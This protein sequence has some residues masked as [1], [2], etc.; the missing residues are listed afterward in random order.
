M[1]A[2]VFSLHQ[3]NALVGS[4][5]AAELPREVLLTA[6]LSE[7]RPSPRGYCFV[8]FV[9]RSE[10]SGQLV[11]KARGTIWA[12]V[13]TTLAPL[14]AQITGA[15]LTAG[16]QVLVR[17]SADFHPLYGYALTVHDIDPAYTVGDMARRR[18]EIL[19]R[20]QDDGVIAL[21][22]E[23][24]EPR[25]LRRIALISSGA[26]AGYG[27]FVA[28][29]RAS[30]HPFHVELFQATMQGR[31]VEGSIIAALER[32][33][34]RAAD[35]DAV[36]IVRGGGAVS[37]LSGFDAYLLAA[38]VAQF[39]LPVFTGIGHERD[40]TVIDHVAHLRL[41]TPTAVA[42]YFID[43]YRAEVELVDSLSQRLQRALVLSLQREQGR[44]AERAQRI[45]RAA[46]GAVAAQRTLV[47]HAA[48]RLHRAL[49]Q[50]L[51]AEQQRLQHLQRQCALASP[52]RILALG[53]SI[54]THEGRVVR[55]PADAPRGAVLETRTAGGVITSRVE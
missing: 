17:V 31:E 49:P 8:E 14:F 28:Q 36:A 1:S 32:I 48:D 39:P 2:E 18:R 13:Y 3:F 30:G 33:V 53:F 4:V 42:A 54:T 5:L 37:D 34:A 20:L 15:P 43:S 6:E 40:E 46:R 23:L 47:Q 24:P 27:D 25:P 9:E 45:D 52:D 12:D 55:T 44:L 10:A 21:N 19:A 29:L 41:K 16:M 50:R 51:A 38:H 7:V 35:F 11:A 22:R 26:A